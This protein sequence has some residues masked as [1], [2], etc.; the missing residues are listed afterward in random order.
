METAL[1]VLLLV[2][3]FGIVIGVLWDAWLGRRKRLASKYSKFQAEK[4]FSDGSVIENPL[5][6]KSN[7]GQQPLFATQATPAGFSATSSSIGFS[8][9]GSPASFQSTTQP[10]IQT[11]S[12]HA[13]FEDVVL[14]RTLKDEPTVGQAPEPEVE[15]ELISL[16]V[17]ARMPGVFSGKKL[18]KAFRDVN[19]FYG[20]MEIFH[21]H[22]NM[23]GSG[24]KVFSV[25]SAFEPGT[26]N[27]NQLDN[28]VTPGIILFFEITTP[29]QSITAFEMLLRTAKQLAQRLDGELRDNERRI[30]TIQTI[31][32]YRE[33]LRLKPAKVGVR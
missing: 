14:V 25:A 13:T 21:R 24:N 19:L 4:T 30:L 9:S 10:S 1:R 7:F 28:F 20:E 15:P 6:E 23:D 29:N 22:E 3:G 27:L 33:K 11:T 2:V 31:E 16:M 26:F 8:Y 17:M 18:L 5:I 12:S 32:Q